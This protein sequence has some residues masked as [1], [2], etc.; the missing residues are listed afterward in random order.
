MKTWFKST[1]GLM[2]AATLVLS[3]C[4]TKPAPKEAANGGSKPTESTAGASKKGE[5]FNIAMVTDIG[6]VNDKS[7]NQSAWEGL[8]EL[9]KETGA[10]VKYQQ[11]KSDADF[12]PH[13]NSY[14][15][16]KYNLIWGIGFLMGDAIKTVAA[17]N[18]K[19]NFAIIDNV[20]EGPNVESVTFAEQEGAYLTGVVAGLM[21][22]TNKVGFVG[23]LKIPVIERFEVGFKAGVAAANPNAKVTINYTASFDKPDQGKAAAATIYN[24]GA[25]IIFHA[26]GGT[27]NG[28]FNEAKDRFKAGKKVWV[29]GVDKDQSLEFGD[30]VTLTSL[31]KR[32]DKAVKR[33]SMDV[34]D[35]K[36]QGGK[37]IVLGLK[38]DGLGLP[39]TSK[40][41]VPADVLKKVDEYKE[42]IVK[43]EIKIPEK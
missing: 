39:E 8:N 42:K 2:L 38:D 22:K 20:V 29:I 24:D 14:V 30:D 26:A 10:N 3:G 31:V 11:S 40:K 9:K 32:V 7:F 17:Q 35:G 18:P 12:I 43:G 23:G 15:K 19:S 37:N 1:A 33:V 6:G 27:G 25:D 5:K 34:I 16:D 36:F 13:L 21:T 28:V 4:G 41:N